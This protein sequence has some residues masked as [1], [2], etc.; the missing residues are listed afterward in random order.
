MKTTDSRITITKKMKAF[1]RFA[2][3]IGLKWSLFYIYQFTEGNTKWDFDKVNGEGLFLSIFMLL[4]LPLLEIVILFFPFYLA[5]KQK[6]W[7]AIL[8]LIL[9]FGL[10]FLIGWY[11][12]NQH[13][14]IWMAV[15]IILSVGLF[16]LIYRKQLTLG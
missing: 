6:G 16:G 5:L 3:Y 4:I 14:E 9:A 2:G 11:A 12:T 15:K 7:I 13:F 8:I 10:E 1:S